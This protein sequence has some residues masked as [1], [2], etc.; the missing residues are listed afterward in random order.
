M[1]S[2]GMESGRTGIAFIGAGNHGRHHI[3]EFAALSG[4]LLTAVYDV[5]P[6]RAVQ[7]AQDFPPL[8][9]AS[10]LEGL[11]DEEDTAGVVIA[12][13]AH[14]HLPLVRAA[15][16]AGKHILLEKPMAHTAP[17]AREIATLAEAHPHLI[18]LVGHCERFNRAYIVV[19]QARFC[20][21][22]NAGKLVV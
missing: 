2:G 20:P 15:L 17:D 14:T 1:K 13:P 21:L 16:S 9:A 22:R 11:L 3:K 6:E 8:C 5:D 12:T 19:S 10:D 7:A 18:L 4:A